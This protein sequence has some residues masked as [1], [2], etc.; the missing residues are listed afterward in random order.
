MNFCVRIGPRLLLLETTNTNENR[1]VDLPTKYE[2]QRE[3]NNGDR[4]PFV[5]GRNGAAEAQLARL[6]EENFLERVGVLVDDRR[7]FVV[8]AAV[9]EHEPQV[10]QQLLLAGIPTRRSQFG[11][12]K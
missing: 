9:A 10:V 7:F 5:F 11:K 3:F 8:L 12:K 6:V 1:F 4:V 2:E